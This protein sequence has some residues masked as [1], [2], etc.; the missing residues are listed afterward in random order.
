MSAVRLRERPVRPDRMNLIEWLVPLGL[1]LVL[2]GPALAPGVLLNLDL[3]LVPHLD[4]PSGFWGLGPELPRRLSLWVPISWLSPIIPA[5]F[6]GKFLMVALFVVS[7]TGMAR[8]TRRIDADGSMLTSQAAAALYTLSP[9]VL[10]RIAVGH[11][12]VTWPHAM[13]P[14]V[15]PILVRPGRRLSSTFL[16]CLLLGFAGHFAGSIAVTVV[17]VAVLVGHRDRWPQ[18]LLVAVAAQAPWLVPGLVVAA[19]NEIEMAGG[20]SFPTVLGGLGGLFR[21]SAGG[22]FW[23]T[24]FQIGEEGPIALVAGLVL[25]ALAVAGTRS[26]HPEFR[27]P[28]AVLG[29]VGWFVATV[30]AIPVLSTGFFWIDEHVLGG[31]WREPHRVLTLHLLWLAPAAALG[32]RRAHRA[33]LGRDRWIPAAGPALVLPFA[34]AVALSM[35][36]LWGL[37]GQ[38]RAEPLPSSWRDAR[39]QVRTDP[40]TVLALPWYQY[41][42]VSVSGGP[43]RR[44]LNPL[45]LYLGGDVLS[46][47]DNSLQP[48]VREFGDPREAQASAAVERLLSGVSVSDDLAALGVRWVIVLDTPVRHDYSGLDDDAGL[49]RVVDGDELGLYEVLNWPG[50]AVTTSGTPVPVATAMPA[51]ARIDAGDDVLWS[52][53]GSDGWWRGWSPARVATDGRVL[54]PAGTAPVWHIGVLP[55]L[56]AQFAPWAMAVV[57]VVRRRRSEE[58]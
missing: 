14:W 36:A 33:C 13:L 18:A 24:Y 12:M 16:A 2:L 6:S 39:E 55:S 5:T 20:A 27:R 1:A 11:F 40:G 53:A 28:M 10:T 31:I 8:L 4:I 30:S 35:P 51:W 37:G 45:P 34:V 21:L 25:L 38:L 46:S 57:L 56:A 47:S 49:R 41:F 26:I 52:R 58:L 15:L 50:P 22:G 48:G 32:S 23:N 7:W 43:M 19:T 17:A 3:V 54:L 29:V 42:N 9:F 44:V